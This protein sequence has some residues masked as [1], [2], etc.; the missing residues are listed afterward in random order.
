[1]FLGHPSSEGIPD[2]SLYSD[3]VTGRFAWCG[4]HFSSCIIWTRAVADS[5]VPI[6]KTCV[7]LVMEPRGR[8]KLTLIIRAQVPFESPRPLSCFRVLSLLFVEWFE[9]AMRSPCSPLHVP[10]H[11]LLLSVVC[12]SVFGRKNMGWKYWKR[13]LTCLF[14]GGRVGLVRFRS[15][16]A[17]FRFFVGMFLFP[18]RRSAF[19]RCAPKIGG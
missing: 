12:S 6:L 16:C 19:V 14:L 4:F 2:R 17:L 10:W 5:G 8:N 13:W 15:P 9:P 18:R 11:L 3:K 7:C 1:M